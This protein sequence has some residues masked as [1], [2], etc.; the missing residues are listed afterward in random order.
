MDITQIGMN[1]IS[2]NSVGPKTKSAEVLATAQSMS[3]SEC[4][5]VQN[6]DNDVESQSVSTVS[7]VSKNDTYDRYRYKE[8]E[9]ESAK[10]TTVSDKVSEAKEETKQ[11]EKDVVSSI[12]E[13]LDVDEE[14]VIEAM[15]AMGFSVFDLLNPQNLAM[16]VK[17]ITGITDDTQILLNAD[18]KQLLS[19][20]TGLGKAFAA[21][22]G[23]EPSDLETVNVVAGADEPVVVP[24]GP[25]V[26]P[27]EEGVSGEPEKLEQQTFVDVVVE[28]N[29]SI[30]QKDEV[31]ENSKLQ[32]EN[33]GED[34]A[35][36]TALQLQANAKGDDSPQNGFASERQ[37]SKFDFA[38][39]LAATVNENPNVALNSGSVSETPAYT[40][41]NTIDVIN[42]II[43]NVKLSLNTDNTTIE[44]QLNPENLGKIYLNVTTREGAVSAQLYAQNEEVKIALEAQIATLT[45]NLNQAGVKVDAVEVAVA[46]H[47]FERNL[48]QNAKQEEE[49]GKNREEKKSSR[50][51]LRLDSLDELSGLMTE[52]EA[53]I[54]QMMRDNGNSVDFTA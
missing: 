6:A 46:T 9:M 52:E 22:I 35:E 32:L 38:E 42:Q 20:V 15:E 33:A 7:D 48:E 28:D 31:A 25:M 4:L 30:F 49:Q 11:F 5:N 44:M 40:S 47:E 21:E 54:A 36:V 18:F 23:V 43:E 51:S 50:R 17:E 26:V 12:S 1:D 41:V 27:D 53:L 3:F 24:D 39:Q 34:S 2:S 16:L 10:E 29:R 19:D 8:N 45:E 37:N 13:E 14:Q